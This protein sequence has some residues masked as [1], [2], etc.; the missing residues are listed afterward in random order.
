MPCK[1]CGSDQRSEF[2]SEINLHFPDLR[3]PDEQAILLFPRLLVC[4]TCG[5][6]EFFLSPNELP[7]V[8]KRVEH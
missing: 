2:A 8:T 1:K 3:D 6:S 5:F 7:L 4:L